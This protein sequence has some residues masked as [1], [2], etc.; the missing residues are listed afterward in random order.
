MYSDIPEELRALVEPVLEDQDLELVDLEVIRGRVPWSVR[1]T[2]DTPSGDGRVPIERCAEVSR[3]VG[4]RLEAADA[5]PVSY[6]LE[7]S[8]P[9]LDRKLS[10]EKDFA[11]ACGSEVRIETRRPLD[12]RRRFRGRLLAF[13]DGNARVSV[14]GEPVD[15]PFAEVARANTVYSF[16]REDFGRGGSRGRRGARR[17]AGE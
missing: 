14:D 4:A 1:L 7:V 11:R 2:I 12:G 5:I 13:E 9:G 16:S 6:A 3:E 15:I 8:S 17:G 10:R